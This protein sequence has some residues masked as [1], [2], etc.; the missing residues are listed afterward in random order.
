MDQDEK[1]RRHLLDLAALAEKRYNPT[2]SGFLNLAEQDLFCRL[3]PEFAPVRSALTG[4]FSQAERKIALFWPDDSVLAGFVPEADVNPDF[5]GLAKAVEAAAPISVL[6]I[7]PVNLRFAEELTH[8]DYLGAILNLGIDRSLTGDIL[9]KDHLAYVFCLENMK[10][11]LIRDLTRVRNTSVT[12][13]EVSRDIPELVPEYQELRVNVAS[14]RLDA[15]VAALAGVS[16]SKAVDLFPAQRVFVNSRIITDPG[17]KLKE[18]DVLSV[19][20]FGKAIYQGIDG[21][22][23]KG[24]L[25]VTLKKFV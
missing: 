24:R 2:N 22:S 7:A 8:R 15:V 12:V 14:E 1:L 13:S 6:L 10:E 25:Y 5:S 11:L 9:V 3:Q 17:K 19:R 21:E 23:R 4:G 18:G 16:R 20:G